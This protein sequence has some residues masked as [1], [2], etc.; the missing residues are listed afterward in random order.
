MCIYWPFQLPELH[1]GS[2]VPSELGMQQ[3]LPVTHHQLS[4]FLLRVSLPLCYG[5]LKR[6]LFYNPEITCSRCLLTAPPFQKAA[7]VPPIREEP[8]PSGSKILSTSVSS[9]KA[10]MCRFQGDEISMKNDASLLLYSLAP[11]SEV[12]RNA[13]GKT[14]SVPRERRSI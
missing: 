9:F 10:G 14:S 12:S 7:H 5:R 4:S 2:R 8:R 1:H 6:N 13:K 11:E 3:A